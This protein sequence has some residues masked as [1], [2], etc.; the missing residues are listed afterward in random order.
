MAWKVLGLSHTSTALREATRASSAF[1]IA[2]LDFARALDNAAGVNV[3]SGMCAEML[4]NDVVQ[5]TFGQVSRR[6]SAR[7]LGCRCAV[8]AV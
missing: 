1:E 6:F 5:C 3:V 7:V 2:P 4:K 8:V